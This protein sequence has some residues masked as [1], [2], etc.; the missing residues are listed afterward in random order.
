MYWNV[1]FSIINRYVDNTC[2]KFLSL[3]K[4]NNLITNSITVKSDRPFPQP[5]KGKKRLVC[6][7]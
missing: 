7:N 2:N 4:S 3:T 1:L 5:E 6:S